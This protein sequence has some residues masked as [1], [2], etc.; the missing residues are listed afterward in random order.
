MG[1]NRA[2]ARPNY[3]A[4]GRTPTKGGR[5]TLGYDGESAIPGVSTVGQEAG[6]TDRME[7]GSA[8]RLAARIEIRGFTDRLA[9]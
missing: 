8:D 1:R 3:P 6:S 5:M 2:N 9:P 4:K 7:G